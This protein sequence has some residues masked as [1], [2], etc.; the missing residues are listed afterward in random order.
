M[1][2]GFDDGIFVN[3]HKGQGDGRQKCNSHPNLMV[4]AR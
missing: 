2:N 3:M 4:T 1:K